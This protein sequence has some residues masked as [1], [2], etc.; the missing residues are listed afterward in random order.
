VV[1][2]AAG[3]FPDRDAVADGDFFRADEDVFDQQAQDPPAVFGAGAG[4]LAAE[5]GEEAFEVV[6]ELEVGVAVGGLS[7]E[8]VELAAKARLAGAQAASWRAARR[9]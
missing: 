3:G 2:A 5:L 6:G 1:S 7:V 4:G 8:G 9:W